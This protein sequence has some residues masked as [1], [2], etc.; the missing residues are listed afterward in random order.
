VTRYVN[1]RY[2]GT[3]TLAKIKDPHFRTPE[4]EEWKC[5]YFI[6]IFGKAIQRGCDILFHEGKLDLP[7]GANRP[8]WKSRFLQKMPHS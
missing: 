4:S 6:A 5:D 1:A 3:L 2:A 8:I 7:F